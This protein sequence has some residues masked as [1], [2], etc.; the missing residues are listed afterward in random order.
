MRVR[1]VNFLEECIGAVTI[2]TVDRLVFQGTIVNH[3]DEDR[4]KDKCHIE[5]N[6]NE[7]IRVL[8]SCDAAIIEDNGDI[9]TIDPVLF[10]AGD[11][12]RINV[13]NIIVIGPSHGCI[14]EKG[15]S[16]A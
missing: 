10:A 2:V 9:T 6:D 14:D 16:E 11:T 8:L 13:D 4:K 3:R 12:V 7:F 15:K 5:E 1:N